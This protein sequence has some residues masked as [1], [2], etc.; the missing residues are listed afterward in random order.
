MG[1]NKKN[2]N[3]RVDA[4][5]WNEVEGNRSEICRQALRASAEMS[6][7]AGDVMQYANDYESAKSDLQELETEIE[8]KRKIL[9]EELNDWGYDNYILPDGMPQN[10]GTFQ[11][12]IVFASQ[13]AETYL[14]AGKERE[15]TVKRVRKD[16]NQEG[17]RIPI[18]IAEWIVD[19]VKEEVRD[20]D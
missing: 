6:E 20:R 14:E 3:I 5:V 10:M 4:D 19:N 18:G 8:V 7:E 1:D 9:Y 2:V 12:T 11:E 13:Y 16:M 15:E 17:R